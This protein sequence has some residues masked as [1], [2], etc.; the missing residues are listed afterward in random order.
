MQVELITF[1]R[2]MCILNRLRIGPASKKELLHRVNGK[3]GYAYGPLDT[4]KSISRFE[5]DIAR[6]RDI[7]IVIQYKEKEYHL[8]NAEAIDDL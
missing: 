5:H 1:R 3:V 8:I 6:L 4:R 7:G 2:I